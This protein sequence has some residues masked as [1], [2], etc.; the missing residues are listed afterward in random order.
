MTLAPIVLF[1]YN[2]PWHTQKTVEALQKNELAEDS[3]LII[4][5]DS[6]KNDN[7]FPQVK[8]VRDYL[9]TIIGF[10]TV[11]IIE[12]EENWGLANSI[13][14]GVT[15]VVHD[16]GTVIVLEDD[17]VTSPKFLKFMNEALYKYNGHENVFSITGY[18]F[19]DDVVT[20]VDSTYFLPITSS[21]SWATW[22]D[23]WSFFN[24]KNGDLIIQLQKES[25]RKRFN[26]NDSCFYSEMLSKQHHNK[27]DSWAISWYS[28]VFKKNGLTLYPAKRL[29]QNIGYDGSGVHCGDAQQDKPLIGFNYILTDNIIVKKNI[30]LLVEQILKKKNNQNLL[31]RL[32]NKLKKTLKK[33]LTAQQKQL[34][35]IVISKINLLFYKKNVGKKSYVDKSVHVL[36]WQHVRIGTNTLIGEQTWLNVND[37]E[38]NV[39]H[40]II[41][42]NCYIGRRNLLSSSLKI[43]ISDF[44]MTSNDCKFLGNNHIYSDPMRPYILTG[45]TNRD[46][47]KIGAN[48]WV[49]AGVNVLGAVTIG[50]GSIIG[51]ASVVTKDIPP[52]SIAVGNPCKVIKRFDFK[53]KQWVSVEF[54]DADKEALMPLEYDYIK[55]LRQEGKGF[56][57]PK[58]AATSKFGDLM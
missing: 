24:N 37:K 53:I 6:S 23:K 9:I 22:K 56:I 54:F 28:S 8:N 41:G 21:W 38:E 44:V 10:K 13:T 42:N 30:S 17:L 51:A 14:D 43:I 55:V 12:R 35:F 48:V 50:H 4:Y 52:F 32:K 16:Y 2:R 58:M 15:K 18:S 39:D 33:I 34:L 25:L 27:I 31:S 5:S 40:I 45:T 1:V 36:G 19:T 20:D 7:D 49:G 3:H 11:T 47:Q 26:F 57:M 29:V 46:I